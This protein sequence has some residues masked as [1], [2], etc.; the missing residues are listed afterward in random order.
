MNPPC[1]LGHLAMVQLSLFNPQPY[2]ESPVQLSLWPE[3]FAHFPG[4][5]D[6]LHPRDRGPVT[7]HLLGKG[8]E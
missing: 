7:G 6:D 4:V 5:V 3:V 2:R 8:Y 1:L